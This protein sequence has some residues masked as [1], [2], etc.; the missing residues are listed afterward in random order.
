MIIE[1]S[2]KPLTF[3]KQETE[4]S[5]RVVPGCAQ[6]KVDLSVC[7]ESQAV[8]MLGLTRADPPL[9]EE[10]GRWGERGA[11]PFSLLGSVPGCHPTAPWTLSGT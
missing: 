5:A 2:L 9:E 3:A 4:L 7:R 10:M 11:L 1:S 6:G 8:Q